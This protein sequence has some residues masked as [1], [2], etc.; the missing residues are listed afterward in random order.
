MTCYI[1]TEENVF[2]NI[3]I[4]YMKYIYIY[5]VI[6]LKYLYTIKNFF[7]FGIL[8]RAD[9]FILIILV[10]NGFGAV[11]ILTGCFMFESFISE[12]E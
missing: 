9:I 6:L 3:M 10:I 2:W 1:G 11:G 8:Q 12:I 4:W 5:I 7:L